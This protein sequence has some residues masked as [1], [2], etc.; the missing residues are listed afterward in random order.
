MD[1]LEQDITNSRMKHIVEVELDRM[2]KDEMMALT[3][4]HLEVI[5]IRKNN[6]SFIRKR[7]ETKHCKNDNCRI[8]WRNMMLKARKKDL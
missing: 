8:D 2:T 3:R 5:Q 1:K 6:D 7:R 4:N